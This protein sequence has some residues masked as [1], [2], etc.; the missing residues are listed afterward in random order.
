M[1]GLTIAMIVLN[2][3]LS[4]GLFLY[5]KIGSSMYDAINSSPTGCREIIEKNMG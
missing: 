4:I 2:I 1:D 3:I 5:I